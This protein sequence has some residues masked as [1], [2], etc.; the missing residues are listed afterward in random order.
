MKAKFLTDLVVEALSDD[1]W[2]VV[3]AL[4]YQS[5]ILNNIIEVPAGFVTDFASVPRV[6]IVFEQFGDRA[7][8]E[9]V[10]HDWLYYT[11][12]TSRK[13]AD[14]VFLEAMKSRGK[15]W[16]ICRGMYLGVRAGGWVAWNAHRKARHP[17]KER[18]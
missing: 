3:S 16:W 13:T 5:Q 18:K 2:Q 14:M 4:R 9:S 6:P 10:V 11:A 15:P 1:T 8:H 17:K 12:S 7:H